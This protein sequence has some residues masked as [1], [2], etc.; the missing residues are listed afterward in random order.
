MAK[1]RL[2]L[3]SCEV[4]IESRD[5][6]VD[7]D[8]AASVIDSIA[9]SMQG[10]AAPRAQVLAAAEAAAAASAGTADAGD[11]GASGS[12]RAAR[13]A[14]GSRPQPPAAAA[15]STAAA[16]PS[17]DQPIRC[18]AAPAPAPAG[19]P[20]PGAD[21]SSALDCLDEAEVFEPEFDEPRR[22][23]PSEV[24]ARLRVLAASGFFGERRTVSETVDMMAERGWL[25]GPLDVSKALARMAMGREMRRETSGY[26]THYCAPPPAE[27]ASPAAAALAPPTP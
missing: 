8:S 13:G 25:A 5:F 4:E 3:D 21:L 22:V 17:T 26:R 9:R 2:R 1:I 16:A 27:P 10:M 14:D 20:P 24:A 18:V 15:A 7:N 23:A 11:T 19:P 6:Y 12:G